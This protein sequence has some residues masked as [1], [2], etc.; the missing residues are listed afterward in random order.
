MFMGQKMYKKIRLLFCVVVILSFATLYGSPSSYKIYISD[1]QQEVTQ[2]FLGIPKTVDYTI[3]WDVFQGNGQDYDPVSIDRPFYFKPRC[4]EENTYLEEMSEDTVHGNFF[5]FHG[6]RAGKKYG[7]LVEGFQNGNRFAVS[8]T[9][10][11]V[12]GKNIRAASSS[13][14]FRWLNWIPF[15][16]RIPM[17]FFKRGNIF[18]GSTQPGKIA[19]HLIWNSFIAGCIIWFFFCIR[20]LKLKKIFPM[21][22]RFH[23]PMNYDEAYCKGISEEFE[24]II[25]DW[26]DIVDK[27]NE[28]VR[29]E[30]QQGNKL[31]VCD[32]ETVNAQFWKE[33]GSIVVQRLLKKTSDPKWNQYPSVRIIHAGLENHELGGFRWLEVSKEVDR[34]I[35]NRASSE[36]ERLRRRSLMDWLWNLGTLAPLV[37]L[38]GTATGISHAFAMLTM[39]QADI[40]QTT[41]VRRL[42]SGIFEALWTTIEGLFVGIILML[43]YYYYQNKLSWIYSK[44]EEIYVHIAEKL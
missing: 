6:K 10:W 18:D 31:K 44:W 22:S 19:F 43:L 12:T 11:I 40:T 1:I 23:L 33:E 3:F 34:A 25:Q 21:K 35:E 32:I 30:I 29:K 26:R 14:I 37:G 17:A 7:I 41:L 9:A 24:Q 5:T 15:N 20:Y 2:K 16:G 42:A 27:T 28:H 39:L 4:W 36:L 8:D 38:F 13:S